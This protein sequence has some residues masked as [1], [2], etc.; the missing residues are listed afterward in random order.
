MI[1]IS[2]KNGVIKCVVKNIFWKVISYPKNLTDL[3]YVLERDCIDNIYLK[4]EITVKKNGKTEIV[5]DSAFNII[6]KSIKKDCE[7][8]I[9]FGDIVWK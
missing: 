3:L 5:N 4:N 9:D 8:E 2:V 1:A 6:Q 7:I